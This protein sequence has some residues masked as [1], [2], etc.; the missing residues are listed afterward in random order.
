LSR[1]YAAS[2]SERNC[3]N[4]RIA[5]V[6]ALSERISRFVPVR[7]FEIEKQATAPLDS[8]DAGRAGHAVKG[9]R[10]V[11]ARIRVLDFDVSP[12]RFDAAELLASR[13]SRSAFER[14]AS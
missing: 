8:P 13:A 7:I 10:A 11:S 2:K 3:K 12:A 9:R 1:E 4:R 14:S 6:L 5:F